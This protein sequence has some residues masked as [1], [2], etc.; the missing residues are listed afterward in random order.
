MKGFL[1]ITKKKLREKGPKLI[2]GKNE[3]LFPCLVLK[4]A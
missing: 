2:F 4:D 3:N 1:I